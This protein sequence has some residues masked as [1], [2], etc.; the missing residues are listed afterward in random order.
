M[1]F[2]LSQFI[3]RTRIPILIALLGVTLMFGYYAAT[4][5]KMDNTFGTMLPKDSEAKRN[6]VKLKEL[7]GGNESLMF[8]AIDNTD[9]YTLKKY[10]AWY[11][12]GEE[13]KAHPAIDSVFSEAH[14]YQ[15]EKNKEEKQFY[16]K[17]ILAYKPQSQLELDSVKTIIK[18]N[19]FY[20]DLIYNDEK[21]ASLMMIFINE[22]YMADLKKAKVIL[23]L[24]DDI[25]KFEE[26][27]GTIHISGLP[28]I[29]L[30]IGEKLQSELGLFIGLSIGVTSLLLLLFFRSLKIVLICNIVVFVGVIWSLGSI[31]FFDFRLSILM[32]L[33]PPLII[34][35]SIPNSIFLIN[36]FHQ[37]IKNH[38]NK[39]KALS[40]VIQK[41]GN[42]TFLTNL[43]TALGFST[44]MF[45]N[46][47]RLSEFGMI[48]SLNILVVFLLSI[49][50]LPIVL[51]YSA[52]P[53]TKHLRHLEKKWLHIAVEKLE[54]IAL[55]KRKQ[56]FIGALIVILF[57]IIGGAQMNATG[58]ITGDLPQ[59]DQLNTDLQYIESHFGGSLPFDILIDTKKKNAFI[60]R[61]HEIDN[62]QK[63]LSKY[64]QF[65]KSIS[66]TDGI[67]VINMAYSG[68]NPQKYTIPSI[69]KMRKFEP[70]LKDD[71]AGVN[72][73]VDSSGVITRISIQIKDL[74]AYKIQEVIDSIQDSVLFYLNP[75]YATLDSAYQTAITLKGGE[76]D[77]FLQDFY[78]D[79]VGVYNNLI[80]IYA[81]NN[82]ELKD[83]FLFDEF[84]INEYHSKDD[85]ND[86]LKKAI[87]KEYWDVTYTGTSVV[88]SNGTRY[89]VFNL[90]TSLA[91]AIVLIGMIMA[92]LFRS[93]RMV[94]ISLIPNFIPLLFTAAM[95]GYFG[96]PVKPSTILVFSIAFGISVDDT[97]HFLA[98][99]RQE[100]KTHGHDFRR[101]ILV[102][103][104]ETGVSMIYTSIVLFFGFLVFAFS[105]FG[106][107]QALGVLVSLTLLVAMFSNLL[108]LPALL[109]Y[110]QRK[111]TNKALAEPLF[112][113]YDEEEDIDFERLEIEKGLKKY[114][115]EDLKH[116]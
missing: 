106:G 94:I 103:L 11:E 1:W 53:K 10:N 12:L 23:K 65:S 56:V 77:E 112:E 73:F 26:I 52:I 96:I 28:H 95:M 93:F 46:S 39:A 104:R 19:P 8:F 40:R 83:E 63:Y 38:G 75:N 20:K 7:F 66:V 74:G 5:I 27:L 41:I 84:K 29:R 4:N 14:L 87:E 50:I 78:F 32:V 15:L 21:N 24:E 92:L 98:K 17:K 22:D 45:T 113:L 59:K 108:V 91:I 79:N 16:F 9:L 44:F 18:S 67:K 37:E 62:V 51:S 110:M 3:L 109:F 54:Y 111:M 114:K 64:T 90:F 48:A 76:K 101:C 105:E 13:L 55:Y 99:F 89:M 100:L 57:S 60:H 116:Q 33:I 47:E 97:I 107:T 35:I 49:T 43:T 82:E 6:Y 61:F 36:K 2:K 80:D 86:N 71:K 70:Y 69:S 81:G 34:V 42:A 31:G 115:E 58:K 25:K 102:A 88:A 68:N 30:T 72:P 85:F